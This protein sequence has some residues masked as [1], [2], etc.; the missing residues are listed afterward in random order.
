MGHPG[1]NADG[2]SYV[3][4][5]ISLTCPSNFTRYLHRRNKSIY[6]KNI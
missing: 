2:V 4:K 1:K 6:P 5:H 3:V